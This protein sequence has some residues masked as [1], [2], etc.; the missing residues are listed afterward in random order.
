MSFNRG[1]S[2][3]RIDSAIEGTSDVLVEDYPD[4]KSL[5]EIPGNRAYRLNAPHVYVDIANADTMLRSDTEE[6]V[7][8]HRRFLRFLHLWD[9]AAHL[10]FSRTGSTKVDFQNHRLHFIVSTPQGDERRRIARAVATG[11]LLRQLLLAANELHE[12]LPDA[13][14]C[15]GVESGLSLAV[16]NGTNGDREPLFLGDP[17]NLAAKLAGVGGGGVYLGHDA[18]RVLGESWRTSDAKAGPLSPAQVAILVKEAALGV[19]L[20]DLFDQWK[21]DLAATPL[22]EFD[23]HRPNPPLRDLDFEQLSPR[24]TARIQS[25]ALFADVDGY[26]RFISRCL[27]LRNE[28]GAV[29]ALHVIRKELR[30]VLRDHGG[31][32]VRYI[33]DCLVGVLAEG[34]TDTDAER[35]VDRATLCA[36]AMRDAFGIIRDRLAAANVVDISGLG[37]GIGFDL[38]TNVITRFGV[39]AGRDRCLAGR[40]VL[41]AQLAQEG[42]SGKE[43]AIGAAALASGSKAVKEIFGVSPK[44]GD[45]NYNYVATLIKSFDPA[46]ATAIG[47]AAAAPAVIAGRAYAK[48]LR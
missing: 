7:R 27:S 31:R 3:V 5:E 24:H 45:L 30:D 8:S 1:T 11:H 28:V 43:T 19:G 37:L 9:R 14:V 18:R 16:R 36:A 22:S 47:V 39:R 15:V 29:R 48:P 46:R 13:R 2:T 41:D 35:T 42:T 32:K 40:A 23:F 33:G 6:G 4:G 26:T 44:R 34:T 20:D 38:G 12:E 10:V 21:S 25:V 17:A